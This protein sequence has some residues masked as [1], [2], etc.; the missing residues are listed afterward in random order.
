MQESSINMSQS[1]LFLETLRKDVE[2]SIHYIDKSI[3]DYEGS[4][5]EGDL[6]LDL[7]GFSQNNSKKLLEDL[8]ERQGGS[9][10]PEPI[11]D[12]NRLYYP[13]KSQFAM[14]QSRPSDQHYKVMNVKMSNS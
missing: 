10:T 2:R 11:D 9:L 8:P 4:E 12:K 7:K 1:L 5:V 14:N 6:S 13:K 3:K